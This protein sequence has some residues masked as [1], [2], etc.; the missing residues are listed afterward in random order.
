MSLAAAAPMGVAPG[1]MGEGLPR[2]FISFLVADRPYALP[3]ERVAEIV[4]WR[5]LNK[6]PHMPRAVEGILDLRGRVF[7][8][9]SLR[10]RMGL[11]PLE[12]TKGTFILI[13]DLAGPPAAILVDAVESV[14]TVLPE[15]LMPGSRLLAGMEG[16]WVCGFILQASRIVAELDP[17]LV[18]ALGPVRGRG[19]EAL[20]SLSLEQ[21]M[22]EGLKHLLSLAPAKEKGEAG[23]RIIPQIEESLKFTEQ[24]MDKV[25]GKVEEMLAFTDR[26]F[27]QLVF[28]KQEAALGRLKGQESK[29]ADLEKTGQAIQDCV[30]ELI[31]TVQFQDISR[32][33]L[34]RVL[35]H[36]QGMQGLLTA[37][38]RDEGH[39]S[40]L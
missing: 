21:R 11:P 7:P 15:Q 22:D 4:P 10:T 1:A 17:A 30:F 6:M 12:S 16:A 9:I 29:I 23:R 27:Q 5:E 32:Q 28:L 38:L 13:L 40:E 25:L 8:V 26:T 35:H 14:A 18:A 36:L 24:E 19:A 31:G 2:K 3:L 39:G 33:K 37:R 20:A 34:E